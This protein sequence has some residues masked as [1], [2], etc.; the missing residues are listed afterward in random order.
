[1]LSWSTFTHNSFFFFFFHVHVV[2]TELTAPASTCHQTVCTCTCTDGHFFS[3][4]VGALTF[5]SP[6]P[7]V[8][9]TYLGLN[10][11]VNCTTDEPNATVKLLHQ[12][13]FPNW[14]ERAVKPNKLIIRGQVFTL[15]NVI[16]SDGGRYKCGATYKNETIEW[17]RGALAVISPGKLNT[18]RI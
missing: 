15:L 17:P 11:N 2:L 10:M 12:P 8:L 1:M 18:S 3:T 7:P 6:P 16:V 9:S 13:A 4:G 14:V 5:V